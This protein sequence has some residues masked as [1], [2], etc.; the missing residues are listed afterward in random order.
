MDIQNGQVWRIA[1][2]F[3]GFDQ[4]GAI[5]KQICLRGEPRCLLPDKLFGLFYLYAVV[6]T[7]SDMYH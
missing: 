6:I 5:G 1:P 7:Y 3:N 2:I 4:P